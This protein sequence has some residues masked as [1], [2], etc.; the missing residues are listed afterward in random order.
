MQKDKDKLKNK[1]F[2]NTS[3]NLDK[4]NKTSSKIVNKNSKTSS[5]HN[6]DIK[7]S[8]KTG[9]VKQKPKGDKDT[10]DN[11]LESNNEFLTSTFI[12]NPNFITKDIYVFQRKASVFYMEGLIDPKILSDFVLR[13]MLEYC[14]TKFKDVFNIDKLGM[15]DYILNNIIT[16]SKIKKD[17]SKKTIIEEITKGKGILMVDG[18]DEYIIL[19]V[20]QVQSR[21]IDEPPTSA[22]TKGPRAG[23]IENIKTNISCIRKILATSNLKIETTNVGRYSNTMI[24]VMYIEGI[25]DKSIVDK[26][27]QKLNKIDIDGVI[28]SYYV[29]SFLEEHKYSIFREAGQNEKPDLVAA[30]ML[31]G[32]VAILVDGSPVVLTIPFLL[33]EDIQ[34]SNDYYSEHSHSSFVRVLRILSIFITIA[35]PG[36]FIAIQIH[37]YKAFPLKFLVTIINSTQNLPLTPFLEMLLVL[38]LFEILYEASLRMPKYMGIAMSVVG[39]LI[40]GDTAVKAGLVSPP[41]VMIVAVS[42]ITLYTVPDQADQ[43]SILR[44]ALTIIGGVLGI[45]GMVLFGLY[46]LY[47][48]ND[49]DSYGVAYLSP[50]APYFKEDTKDGIFKKDLVEMKSRPKSIHNKNK[51]RFKNEKDNDR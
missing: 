4:Y 2:S 29:A 50:Y 47:Y 5:K 45:Y 25:A 26:I 12:N 30:K 24:A 44:L 18:C 41:S 19:D 16:L 36:I 43:I 23:F 9:K 31:E 17:I 28:D 42:G 40:L 39:A 21:S 3:T 51:I 8:I 1:K 46:V 7:T 27:M 35:L 6:K 20:E 11:K 33:F 14:N 49:F 15:I 22:V 10:I 13:P 38:I 37:H 48:L 32:R 34:N